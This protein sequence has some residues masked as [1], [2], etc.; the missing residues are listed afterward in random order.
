MDYKKHADGKD[1]HEWADE[2]PKI[3]VKISNQPIKSR[4]HIRLFLIVLA[5]ME[6]SRQIC[7]L[8]STS[9]FA[10]LLVPISAFYFLLSARA[11]PV[12]P[13]CHFIILPS[14]FYILPLTSATPS[15]PV[16]VFHPPRE[17]MLTQT[18]EGSPGWRGDDDKI[19]CPVIGSA[20]ARCPIGRRQIWICF[21]KSNQ[22]KETPRKLSG[23]RL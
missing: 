8:L 19:I 18:E 12:F 22:R 15:S 7:R 11:L 16:P 20:S 5:T 21:V 6:G 14:A 23:C 3:Q 1:E 9:C 10:R 2:K 13:L 4:S 17:L